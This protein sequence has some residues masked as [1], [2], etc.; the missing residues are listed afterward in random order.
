MNFDDIEPEVLIARGKYSTLSREARKLREA[1]HRKM[2]SISDN[3][4]SA[5]RLL[6][7][8]KTDPGE[9]MVLIKALADGALDDLAALRKIMPAIEDLR[10]QAWPKKK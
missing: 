4:R 7:G 8:E 2:M 10:E 5:V 9:N 1:M 3:T 6:D